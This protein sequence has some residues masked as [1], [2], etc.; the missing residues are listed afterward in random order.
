MDWKRTLAFA[1]M[2]T[3]TSTT[4]ADR[5]GSPDVDDRARPA[6]ESAPSNSVY[7]SPMNP[8]ECQLGGRRFGCDFHPRKRRYKMH[9]GWDFQARPAGQ[10]I[11]RSIGRGKVVKAG[12]LTPTCGNGVQIKLETG[13]YVYY[14]HMSRVEALRQGDDVTPGQTIGRLGSSGAC[15]GPHL[16]FVMATCPEIGERCAVDPSQYLNPNDMCGQALPDRTEGRRC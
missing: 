5:V 8:N 9:S 4:R 15:K 2:L 12:R 16:H 13:L 3:L 14:C 10:P 11:L 6:P 7:V 1:T